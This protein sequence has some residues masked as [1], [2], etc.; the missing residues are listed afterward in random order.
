MPGA[1]PCSRNPAYLDFHGL[2]GDCTNFVSQCLY[3][4][5][6]DHEP[7]AGIRLV[8]PDGQQP[9]RLLDGGGIPLPLSD[10][11]QGRGALRAGG[12]PGPGGTRRRGAAGRPESGFTHTALIVDVQGGRM[13]R[14]R[15]HAGFLDAAPVQL[16]PARAQV[17]A[18]SGRSRQA[19][20][21]ACVAERKCG[22]IARPRSEA[23]IQGKRHALHAAKKTTLA[24]T[25]SDRWF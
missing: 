10:G 4:G 6:G 16:P 25:P 12:Q 22:K 7:H 21:R 5:A 18:H 15:A 19:A 24:G 13:L 8:L 11:Q 17:S 2:G 3:A 20:G 14:G 1:G 9:H 23:S